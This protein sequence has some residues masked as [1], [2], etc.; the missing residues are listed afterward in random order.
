MT[1][2]Q[3]QPCLKRT[4]PAITRVFLPD[5]VTIADGSYLV[6]GRQNGTFVVADPSRNSTPMLRTEFET[7]KKINSCPIVCDSP[8]NL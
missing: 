4:Y 7:A 1:A 3:M 5:Q 2:S 6:D 8:G